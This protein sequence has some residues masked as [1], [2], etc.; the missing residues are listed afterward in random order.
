MEMCFYRVVFYKVIKIYKFL[1]KT[2]YFCPPFF[3][4][5]MKFKY[6]EENIIGC[7]DASAYGGFFSR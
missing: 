1:E 4:F 5:L 6:N 2:Y 3:I 7:D